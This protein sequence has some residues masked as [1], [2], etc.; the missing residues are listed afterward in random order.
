MN[1]YENKIYLYDCNVNR[2]IENNIGEI[3]IPE[4]TM[5]DIIMIDDKYKKYYKDLNFECIILVLTVPF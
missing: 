3:S 1:S 5:K 2:D 4:F